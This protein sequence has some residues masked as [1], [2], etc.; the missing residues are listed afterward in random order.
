MTTSWGLWVIAVNVTALLGLSDGQ[1]FFF[2][3]LC[4]SSVSSSSDVS[5][6]DARSRKRNCT[7][8]NI[9][10][11]DSYLRTLPLMSPSVPGLWFSHLQNEGC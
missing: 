11:L 3:H 2:Q 4:M 9:A 7:K 10:G 1:E 6:C 8:E 5:M